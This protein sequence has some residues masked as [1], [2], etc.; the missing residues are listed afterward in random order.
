M[1]RLSKRECWHGQ[2]VGCSKT[3]WCYRK[4]CDASGP[5]CW[6]AKG[7]DGLGDWL[8]CKKDSDCSAGA[9]CGHS[10]GSP[11]KDCGCSC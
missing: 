8:S 10:K 2:Y 1:S 4:C 7:G 9:T 11:C 5:W 6:T 3:G